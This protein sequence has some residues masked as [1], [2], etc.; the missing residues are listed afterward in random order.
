MQEAVKQCEQKVDN[1]VAYNNSLCAAHDWI[2]TL[3]DQ[4]TADSDTTGNLQSVTTRL[5]HVTQLADLLPEGHAK[6]E[7]CVNAAA[8]VSGDFDS[9]GRQSVLAGVDNLQKMWKQ[10]EEDLNEA[11]RSLRNAVEQWNAYD[12]HCRTLDEWLQ[13]M[14][15][16]VKQK[17][18]TSD[19]NEMRPLVK[20]YQ[21]RIT[22]SVYF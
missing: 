13:T 9:S 11:E 12:E 8:V 22:A 7:A 19:V 4:L 3:S 14:G 1:Y 6:V 10:L 2:R 20:S 15:K 16:S 18:L 17:V 5:Q 21:V